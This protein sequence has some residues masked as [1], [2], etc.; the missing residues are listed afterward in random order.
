MSED[1]SLQHNIIIENR[2]HAV[3]T[4]VKEVESYSGEAVDLVT[5][6][7]NLSIRGTDLKIESFS[8]E[9]GDLDL[10]GLIVAFVY[11]TD[12]KKGGF[13]SRMFK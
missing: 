13:I 8:T 2:K 3:L 9:K 7:G 6:M 10:S 5:V 11:V 12:T 4:G 1:Y